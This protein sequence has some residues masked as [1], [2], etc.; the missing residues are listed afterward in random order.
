MNRLIK[1]FQRNK[2]DSDCK[3]E[4]IM[5]YGWNDTIE[6]AFD[7]SLGLMYKSYTHQIY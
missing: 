4:V 7:L 3:E 5:K 6:A 1:D 2:E